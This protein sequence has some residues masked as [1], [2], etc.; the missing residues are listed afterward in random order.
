[1]RSNLSREATAPTVRFA[2][3]AAR[4][5]IDGVGGGAWKSRLLDVP[6]APPLEVV[7]R[8]F[9]EERWETQNRQ[10]R[11]SQK[12]GRLQITHF[13]LSRE[14][15]LCSHSTLPQSMPLSQILWLI[16]LSSPIV[17]LNKSAMDIFS[18]LVKLTL[19]TLIP[20]RY[21]AISRKLNTELHT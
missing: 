17:S 1:M 20:Y 10:W 11:P 18:T 6:P 16:L 7:S 5:P 3:D 8:I 14:G 13:L 19:I 2:R 12:L 15:N 4:F 21:T 9:L